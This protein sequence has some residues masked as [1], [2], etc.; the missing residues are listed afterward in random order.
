MGKGGRSLT[1]YAAALS[2][3]FLGIIPSTVNLG[4]QRYQMLDSCRHLAPHS[5]PTTKW[6]TFYPS[7]PNAAHLPIEGGQRPAGAKD[8][9]PH[10]LPLMSITFGIFFLGAASVRWLYVRWERQDTGWRIQLSQ[11]S[12]TQLAA[13][14]GI[15]APPIWKGLLVGSRRPVDA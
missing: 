13:D 12:D 15:H 4:L 6:V 8:K 7:H 5:A 1:A 10:Y 14:G 2:I 3:F 11:A 9:S